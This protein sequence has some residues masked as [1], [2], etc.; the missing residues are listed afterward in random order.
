MQS[1]YSTIGAMELIVTKTEARHE[2][3]R[4]WC[5]GEAQAFHKYHGVVQTE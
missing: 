4:Y 5:A 3:F 2:S 1:S